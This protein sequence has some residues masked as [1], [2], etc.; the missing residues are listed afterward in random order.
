[1]RPFIKR[2]AE[3]SDAYV[4]C[5]ANAGL[6]NALGEYDQTPEEMAVLVR[7]LCLDGALNAVGGCC[8]TTSKHIKAIAETVVGLP[9]RQPATPERYTRLSGLE[10][11]ML[12]PSINFVNVGERCNVTGSRRFK[13]LIV[14]GQYETAIAVAREQVENG[15]QVLDINFDEG[16]LDSAHIMAHFLNLLASEPDIS[17]VPI[18][19]D[20]SKFSVIEAGLK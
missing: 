15:A 2:I 18:M 6:P 19:I 16:M 11:L 3:L 8:G 10:L 13:N 4:S 9:P 14:K 7:E 5:Y 20:S 12:E 1:M 17:R